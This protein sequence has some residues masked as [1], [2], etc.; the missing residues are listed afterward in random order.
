MKYNPAGKGGIGVCLTL[1]DSELRMA[2]TDSDSAPFDLN[3]EAPAV[4]LTE[5]LHQRA[6]GKL[7]VHLVKTIMDRVEYAHHNRTST[8]T[9]Y[10]RVG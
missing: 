10:K 9:L 7:G 8:I 1:E 6:R 5:P 2:L 3:T 4:D